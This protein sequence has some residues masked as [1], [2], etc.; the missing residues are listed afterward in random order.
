MRLI[1]ISHLQL[2]LLLML[3]WNIDHRRRHL[4]GRRSWSNWLRVWWL[5]SVAAAA[6]IVGSRASTSLAIRAFL[7]LNLQPFFSPII[8]RLIFLVVLIYPLK[9]LLHELAGCLI[10]IEMHGAHTQV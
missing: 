3:H 2:L 6:G 1:L 10:H 4:W 8:R 7:F 9:Q 5:V